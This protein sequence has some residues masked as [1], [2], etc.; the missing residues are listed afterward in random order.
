MAAKQQ[1]NVLLPTELVRRIKRRA[2]DVQLGL[3]DLVTAVLE[4]HLDDDPV[5]RHGDEPAPVQG[6]RLQP[7]VHV[8][9][10]RAAVTFYEWL[11]AEVVHGS[12]DGDRVLL[13]LGGARVGLLAQPP[14]PA[15]GEGTVE[16]NFELAGSLEA[17]EERLRAAGV[18]VERPA[19]GGG[20]GRRLRVRAPGGLLVTID[21]LEP[22]RY[23]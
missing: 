7:T 22:E 5:V 15:Q 18:P 4:R 13:A 11:G 16:L 21:E 20:S 19:T 12:R 9:D 2:V 6:L 3:S 1:F 17:Y 23:T 8:G 10:M 14:G